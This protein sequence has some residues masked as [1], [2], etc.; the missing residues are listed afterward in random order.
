MGGT[1]KAGEDWE[2]VRSG[3]E[4]WGVVGKGN[5]KWGEVGWS[6]EQRWGGIG[7][8][9]GVPFVDNFLSLSSS[10]LIPRL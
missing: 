9:G 10:I 2:E 4:W 1:R 8:E 3:G 6:K 7:W 5:E